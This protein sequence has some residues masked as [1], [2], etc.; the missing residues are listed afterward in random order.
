GFPCRT[1]PSAPSVSPCPP[2]PPA[3]D[4]SRAICAAPATPPTGAGQR[5]RRVFDLARRLKAIPSLADLAPGDLRPFVKEWHRRA[6]PAIATK[7]FADSY[8]DFIAAW[9]KVRHPAGQG[10]VDAAFLR[11]V[12]ATP[13]QR[14]AE[15]YPDDADQPIRLLASLCR[16]LRRSA[17]D[18]DFYLD[19]RTAGRLLGVSH[20]RAWR[21]LNAL[22]A[23]KVLELRE[24]G[25]LATRRAS[26][27]RYIAD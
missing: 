2:S 18:A 19:C 9:G 1:A 5:H 7:S 20:K 27:F 12:K 13:P 26:S 24:R 14:V 17:G 10:P 11:A 16:E 25:D 21:Y 6:L 8:A 15:L 3:A 23:D 22:C 4:L